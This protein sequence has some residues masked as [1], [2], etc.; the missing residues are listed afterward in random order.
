M[1]CYHLP[2]IMI[3]STVTNIGQFVFGSCGALTNMTVSANNPS[4]S[5]LNGVLLT[6]VKGR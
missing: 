5:S 1:W 4:Y 3:P 6:R 2:S